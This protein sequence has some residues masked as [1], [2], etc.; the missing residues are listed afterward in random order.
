MTLAELQPHVEAAVVAVEWATARSRY[1]DDVTADRVP[2]SPLRSVPMDLITEA[3]ARR[4]LKLPPDVPILRI[5][6]QPDQDVI[7]DVVMALASRWKTANGQT[8]VE[9]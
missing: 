2:Q 6:A 4:A 1:G 7:F 5:K 9:G 3:V 8:A